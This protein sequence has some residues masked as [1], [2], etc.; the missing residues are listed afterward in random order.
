M[1]QKK[2]ISHLVNTKTI[3]KEEEDLYLYA[4][5][6]LSR[7]IINLIT[8]IAIGLLLN[9]VKESIIFFMS[10]FVLRK[11]VGGLHAETYIA[12]FCSSTILFALGLVI[13]KY[14]KYIPLGIW[15]LMSFVSILLIVLY[16]PIEHPNK[17]FNSKEFDVYRKIS[18]FISVT[19]TLISFVCIF[20]SEIS[21]GYS[22]LAGQFLVTILMICGKIKYK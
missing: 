6:L 1:V 5:K 10:F 17:K 20:N 19:I 7:S 13:V 2:I 15:V 4:L 12:C 16:S 22:F 14:A 18:I 9:M 8:V 3:S 11:F 21:V